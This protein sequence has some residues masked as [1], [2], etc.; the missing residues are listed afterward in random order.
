MRELA[1]SIDLVPRMG[2]DVG[3]LRETRLDHR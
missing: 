3:A 2:V 1:A